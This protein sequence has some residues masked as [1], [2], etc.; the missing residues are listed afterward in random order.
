MPETNS[1]EV[2]IFYSH[3]SMLFALKYGLNFHY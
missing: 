2:E 1:S 3:V